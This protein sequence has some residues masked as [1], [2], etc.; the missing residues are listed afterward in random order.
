MK[1]YK[2]PFIFSEEVL[3][4]LIIHSILILLAGIILTSDPIFEFT[5]LSIIGYWIGFFIAAA[6]R[7]QKPTTTD[8]LYV[9]LG[10]FLLLFIG[11][12]AGIP[13]VALRVHLIGH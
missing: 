1:L 9:K 3:P 11:P 12:V 4:Q 13:L 2:T 6:R 7:S 5:S 10:Y 8:V